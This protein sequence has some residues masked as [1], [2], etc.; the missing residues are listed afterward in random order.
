MMLDQNKELFDSFRKIHDQYALDPESWQEKFNEEGQKV[1]DVI[2]KYEN[3]L[4]SRSEGS[5]FA[6]FTGNLSEKFQAEVRILFP[7][8]DYIGLKIKSFSIKKINV[9]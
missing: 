2:R 5:G 3:R 7:K 8:I 4:C 9:L 6:K 1:L